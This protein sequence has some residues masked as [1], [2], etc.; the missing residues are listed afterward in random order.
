MR[1]GTT[2][3]LLLIVLGLAGGAAALA[4][5]AT[6]FSGYEISPGSACGDQTCGTT[7]AGWTNA[8]GSSWVPRRQSN[9][10]HWLARINYRGTPGIGRS[11]EITGGSFAWVEANGTAHY[12]PITGG[13]VT[14]PSSLSENIGCG[15]GVARVSAT[16]AE[17]ATPGSITGCLDDTH[18]RQGVFPPRIWGA[19]TLGA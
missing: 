19:L 2:V 9:G 6:G 15:A 3:A 5:L 10:G 14:W 1:K 16:I 11:V 12:G 4:A 7:F 13:T 17:G 8:A 18:I